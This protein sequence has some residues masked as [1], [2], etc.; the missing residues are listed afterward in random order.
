MD[1]NSKKRKW[2]SRIAKIL[3]RTQLSHVDKLHVQWGASDLY[4]SAHTT[5]F[6]GLHI[7]R[8]DVECPELKVAFNPLAIAKGRI[9]QQ[10]TKFL[11]RVEVMEEGLAR[12]M[13]SPLLA[14]FLREWSVEDND[15]PETDKA[16]PSP[17][18]V[19][20]RDGWCVIEHSPA[21][22]GTV[23]SLQ[24]CLNVRGIKG[25]LLV[26]TFSDGREL[27]Y[28]LGD[29]TRIHALNVADGKLFCSLELVATP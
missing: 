28:A 20:L 23:R 27:E 8:V 24:F 19:Q 17:G 6:R 26:V 12:S 9:L 15:G 1:R 10:D 18:S 4:A 16:F 25:D 7:H 2:L 5:V 3:L 13:D 11:L 29:H 14:T 22:C 21:V